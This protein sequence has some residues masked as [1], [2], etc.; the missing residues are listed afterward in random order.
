MGDRD[1]GDI[2]K[3]G[4]LMFPNSFVAHETGVQNDVRKAHI[5]NRRS[6]I[7]LPPG[8]GGAQRRVRAVRPTILQESTIVGRAALIRRLR[9]TFSQREKD[10]VPQIRG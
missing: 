10:S 3:I 9:A 7:P 2:W 5:S 6:K 8:E 1:R 4:A